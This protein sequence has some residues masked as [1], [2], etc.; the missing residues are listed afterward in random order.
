MPRFT[1]PIDKVAACF[2]VEPSSIRGVWLSG[3]DPWTHS[4]CGA[5]DPN[6]HAVVNFMRP[7]R[8]PIA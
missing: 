7:R 4:S 2:V 3:P 1:D 5:R 8:L 6:V